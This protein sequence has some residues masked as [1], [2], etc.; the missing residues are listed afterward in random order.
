MN[1]DP[2]QNLYNTTQQNAL[3]HLNLN[4]D[5]AGQRAQAQQFQQP[6]QP[7]TPG[8]EYSLYSSRSRANPI[9]SPQPMSVP[10]Q[11]LP[12]Y[13]YYDPYLNAEYTASQSQR[14]LQ[15]ALAQGQGE[16]YISGLAPQVAE[17]EEY[18]ASAGPAFTPIETP[19]RVPYYI[20]YGNDYYNFGLSNP[21]LPVLLQQNM[22][23]QYVTGAA[24]AVQN[25]PAAAVPTTL[26]APPLIE[27]K[28]TG[29]EE[30]KA[31]VPTVNREEKK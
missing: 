26:I 16:E 19:Q 29:K 4:A 15:A 25:V 18:V 3:I 31:R 11:Q 12:Y 14:I 2:F 1:V 30:Q 7:D 24:P 5:E 17:Q 9:D 22:L 28:K 20:P 21:Q 10:M 6:W 27:R 23:S 13:P 8:Q